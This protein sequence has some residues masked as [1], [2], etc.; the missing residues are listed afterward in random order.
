MIELKH[1]TKKYR[2]KT[3]LE[4]VSLCFP[5][6][7]I[8]GLFGEN[9]AG[10]TTLMKSILGFLK[11][12]GEITLDGEKIDWRNIGRI[13]FATSEHSFFPAMDAEGHKAFYQEHFGTFK[14][15][16]FDA[17]ME[18]FELP[19]NRA[20]GKFSTGQKNQFEVLLPG[21]IMTDFVSVLGTNLQL[22]QWM[23]V[24]LLVIQVWSHY[25]YFKQGARAD[26]TLRRLPQRHARFRYCWS[27]PLLEAAVSLLLMV[28][29]LLIFYGYYMYL[30]PDACLAPGQWQKLQAA[31]WGILW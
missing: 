10:K 14:E 25:R 18:F 6:G 5:Q 19:T 28:V 7:E 20:I 8:V 27:L 22:Y 29:M 24:V 21:A 3:A 13:A 17:L 2:N 26:Y 11:Y 16:R 23:A 4:D 9:G 31:G 1:V 15:K 12:S 30:T